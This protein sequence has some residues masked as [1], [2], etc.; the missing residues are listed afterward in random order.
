VPSVREKLHRLCHA[1]IEDR[2]KSA[3]QAILFAQASANEETKS[4]AGDKYETGRAMA[5]LEIEKNQ[6]QLREAQKLS[7]ILNQIKPNENYKLVQPGSLVVTNREGFY[8]SIPAGKFIIDDQIY[9][10]ISPSSP[11]AQKLLGE[12]EGSKFIF[13]NKEYTITHVS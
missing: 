7:A 8:I 4:S 6:A 3:N 12:K 11:I 5:Q 1:Y 2:I 10:A 9:F 13:N